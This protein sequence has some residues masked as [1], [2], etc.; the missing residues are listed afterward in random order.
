[1]FAG[2]PDYCD[3]PAL[4]GGNC[5]QLVGCLDVS[6]AGD[7]GYYSGK[8]VRA[9][10]KPTLTRRGDGFKLKYVYFVK[11]TRAYNSEIG[12][13][14][15]DGGEQVLGVKGQDKTINI[16]SGDKPINVAL[17][18]IHLPGSGGEGEEH[19]YVTIYT[20]LDE[21][22]LM[23]HLQ[24]EETNID[25]RM[26]EFV[27]DVFTPPESD[28][29]DYVL[30]EDFSFQSDGTLHPGSHC[31][32]YSG[33]CVTLD[34]RDED[35]DCVPE[36][37][38]PDVC[39]GPGDNL[40]CA[41][42]TFGMFDQCPNSGGR[43]LTKTAG[44]YDIPYPIDTPGCIPK[45]DGSWD[46]SMVGA[47]TP[48][49]VH[50]EVF[51]NNIRLENMGDIYEEN[52]VE[53]DFL[54]HDKAYMSPFG[55]TFTYRFD[56]GCYTLDNKLKQACAYEAP[57][58]VYHALFYGEFSS[59]LVSTGRNGKPLLCSQLSS[60]LGGLS[61][62]GGE[63]IY[64]DL[65][66]VNAL[67]ADEDRERC[68]GIV[69]T[70]YNDCEVTGNADTTCTQE[71]GSSSKFTSYSD[72]SLYPIVY[73][74][75]SEDVNVKR[76]E[77]VYEDGTF[78]KKIG[79]KMV[80]NQRLV[81]QR[82]CGDDPF[83]QDT[84][85]LAGDKKY[86]CTVFGENKDG[87]NMY[88][89][90][91]Y[92][93]NQGNIFDAFNR[94]A[95]EAHRKYKIE[96]ST[97]L[98]DFP[99]RSKFSA[100]G[101]VPHAFWNIA[102][103]DDEQWFDDP[104]IVDDIPGINTRAIWD[105]EGFGKPGYVFLRGVFNL[106]ERIESDENIF[107]NVSA[108]DDYYV[109]I[110]GNV[111]AE[112]SGFNTIDVSGTLQQGLNII[113]VKA[114]DEDGVDPGFAAVLYGT[115]VGVNPLEPEL[116]D[117]EHYHILADDEGW[118]ACDA[119]NDG[120]TNFVGGRVLQERDI[121]EYAETTVEPEVVFQY[122]CHSNESA[123]YIDLRRGM[124]FT[125]SENSGEFFSVC[126]DKELDN[127]P[128]KNPL[129]NYS[130]KDIGEYIA[131]G[132]NIYYCVEYLG[133]Y[134]WRD[135]LDNEYVASACNAAGHEFNGRYF[136]HTGSKCC[137]EDFF[138]GEAGY[139]EYY[140]D[141]IASR[142]Q[143]PS[144]FLLG[145]CWA[146]VPVWSDTRLYDSANFIVNGNFSD[147]PEKVG[148]VVDDNVRWYKIGT[149]Q[150]VVK[151]RITPDGYFLMMG[152]DDLPSSIKTRDYIPVNDMD[153]FIEASVAGKGQI[154]NFTITYYDAEFNYMTEEVIGPGL[155]DDDVLSEMRDEGNTGWYRGEWGFRPP[156]GTFAIKIKVNVD[157]DVWI[158]DIYMRGS[159]KVMNFKGWFY[160]CNTSESNLAL[161]NETKDIGEAPDN[162]LTDKP[163]LNHKNFCESVNT[164]PTE[165]AN[166]F[167]SFKNGGEWSS[168]GRVFADGFSGQTE[169][170]APYHRNQSA[171][172]PKLT[173]PSTNLEL[174]DNEC[175]PVGY[176]WNGTDCLGND[177]PHPLN[178]TIGM[179][180]D[181]AGIS[182]NIGEIIAEEGYR[183]GER[184]I[185]GRWTWQRVKKD[186]NNKREGYCEFDSQCLVHPEGVYVPT[187]NPYDLDGFSNLENY[188]D[189]IEH[190][191]SG[192]L[193]ITPA[194]IND[195][196][197]IRDHYCNN[198]TWTTR[199]K[200]IASYLI[201]MTDANMDFVLHCDDS[202]LALN[203]VQ[204]SFIL[205]VADYGF[206]RGVDENY[207]NNFCTLTL[208]PGSQEQVV[209]GSSI[210]QLLP[211]KDTADADIGQRSV[212]RSYLV[213][214]ETTL[215]NRIEAKHCDAAIENPFMNY[216]G[217]DMEKGDIWFNNA[218]QS[219]LYSNKEI[220]PVSIS[221]LYDYIDNLAN[222]G[223]TGK[224]QQ[225]LG[226]DVNL[227]AYA[228]DKLYVNHRADGRRVIGYFAKAGE[229][230][231]YMINFTGFGVNLTRFAAGLGHEVE[232]LLN[233][234]DNMIVSKQGS[235]E[236]LS[237]LWI[238]LTAHLR[239][240]LLEG[241][242]TVEEE[243]GLTGD[244]Y[245]CDT[246]GGVWVD[247]GNCEDTCSAM[248]DA[249]GCVTLTSSGCDCGPGR[250]WDGQRCID[251][252]EAWSGRCE[253]EGGIWKT[254]DQ[255]A[256]TF[257]CIPG[258]CASQIF[259]G[260]DCGIGRCWNE[261]INK[262]QPRFT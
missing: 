100:T 228:F 243:E 112:G 86:L 115:Y 53:D 28:E 30:S 213:K 108:G 248:V 92:S 104:I 172:L 242:E 24:P 161:M 130:N 103:F 67:R 55:S 96:Y 34:C 58:N 178:P 185:N 44:C 233:V 170:Y 77:T 107:L 144:D 192:Q 119:Y 171:S 27:T 82:C 85:M 195:S 121:E 151:N 129:T 189:F 126:S 88:G 181:A 63:I 194:C 175:C 191:T 18:Y 49:Y 141:D 62:S 68:Q 190:P 221:W 219:I 205:D 4:R 10:G 11:G 259:K 186:W 6:S 252:D 245:Y 78:M 249:Q 101:D 116:F 127:S 146:N 250:C 262:C 239:L 227:T 140:N 75:D 222:F 42:H 113:A 240:G 110:N 167:C 79:G 114:Y 166:F 17:V 209:V 102:T 117:V 152:D 204:G 153:Y 198:G 163:L 142:Y 26:D 255:D 162:F 149:T 71:E 253:A 80:P 132:N 143:L 87:Y 51:W 223:L 197:F 7:C 35:Q 72:P 225:I 184:C 150:M 207:Y 247:A 215:G 12:V 21:D 164:S 39:P 246:T 234:E 13:I 41:D 182:M 160:G 136:V 46:C 64:C 54:E 94:S 47:E 60:Q 16:L 61:F 230:D 50:G 173:E 176:C 154:L 229:K 179:V 99:W 139:L 133:S 36:C 109:E 105:R 168:D 125:E 134:E 23:A 97:D 131:A 211:T 19:L 31:D 261:T 214:T 157:G 32:Y 180:W 201:N 118:V 235:Y 59:R 196:F 187:G 124:G 193:E 22:G 155:I 148:W 254:N 81:S 66:K 1:V 20:E 8:G 98:N 206:V 5:C 122:M 220:S 199:T 2:F 232:E 231:Y 218:T 177:A 9:V 216:T 29:D 38:N 257:Y 210:N 45:P 147:N 137:G 90:L 37:I 169:Y 251:D 70:M 52:Y 236:S 128:N 74:P 183:D 40:R 43:D 57:A 15:A 224:A 89:W 3:V 95:R 203:P 14:S 188:D 145:G 241:E 73:L 48:H 238:K 208:N 25:A 123:E 56:I 212:F 260:C 217:C 202:F 226:I 106:P 65:D 93:L 158:D 33:Q 111:V 91:D 120:A 138:K 83:L 135:N 244:E 256:C 200:L 84:G 69:Q 159:K 174:Q 258:K 165:Y 237:P 76:K 156:E